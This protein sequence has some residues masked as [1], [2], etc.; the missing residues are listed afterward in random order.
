MNYSYVYV[1]SNPFFSNG[2]F[3]VGYTDRDLNQR[4]SELNSSTSTPAK[5]KVECYFKIKFQGSYKRHKSHAHYIES[6]VHSYLKKFRVNKDRE[7]FQVDISVIHEAVSK[8][9]LAAGARD[10]TAQERIDI[11][12]A[13]IEAKKKAYSDMINRE[14]VA[15]ENEKERIIRATKKA[16][17]SEKMTTIILIAIGLAITILA[18]IVKNH[19]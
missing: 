15:K 17:R 3:K 13:L 2:L 9:L 8:A 1:L 10:E 5:F 19:H 14:Y 18:Q 11:E 16:E 12:A 6:L 7:F 4:I